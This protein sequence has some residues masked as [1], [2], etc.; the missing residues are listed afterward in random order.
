MHWN[1]TIGYLETNILAW[2]LFFGS[3]VTGVAVLIACRNQSFVPQ[4]RS[5]YDIILFVVQLGWH[6]KQGINNIML[7][8]KVIAY[9]KHHVSCL[10]LKTFK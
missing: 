8:L 5:F 3:E 9:L 4:E 6:S 10:N 2:N 7:L 1:F